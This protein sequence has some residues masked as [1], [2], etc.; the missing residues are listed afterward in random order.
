[1]NPEVVTIGLG[2]IGLPTSALIAKHKTSVLGVDINPSVVEKINQGKIHIVEPE[3][4]SVVGEAVENGYL[5]ASTKAE[6]GNVYLVVVPTPFKGNHEPD[7]S[8]VEAATKGIL[9]LLKKGDLYIIE[10]TSPVGTTEKM[11]ELIYKERPD[12]EGK[13]Y[14]AYCPERVLPG[15]VMYELVHNDRVIGGVDEQ[16]TQKAVSF[17]AK[18]VKGKLHAT[19]ARTA[20]M[21]KLVENSSR[22]VQ[23]AFAN[24]LSLICDKAGI[25]VWELI[26][27]ANKHPRVNILQPGCGVG[28]H[29]IAVDPYFIVSDYPMESKIIGTAREVNNYKSFWCAEKIQNTKLQFE[30]KHGRKPKTALMGL[31]FKP[32]IDDLRESPAKYIVNKVLQNSNNEEHFI[33]E[34]NIENHSVF[35]LTD[36]KDAIKKADIIVFLVAHNEF[37][38]ENITKNKIVLDFCGVKRQF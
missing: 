37:G 27:L 36:Y 3:L 22:D 28:G 16:S 20:E 8:F 31:A 7:I 23:I 4:D 38:Y 17:Y 6:K 1:M 19:N 29:C 13:I 24:E 35:K 33:V 26:H 15:N 32:N 21:C 34:P 12:L 11:Q 5:R 9:P 10:S 14:M 25:N 30:L 2:Y 18:Y